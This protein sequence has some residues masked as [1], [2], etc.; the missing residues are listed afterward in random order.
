MRWVFRIVGSVV[1]LILAGFAAVSLVPAEKIADLAAREI[2]AQTG[3]EVRFT[4][5]VKPVFFPVLGIR[6][7]GFTIANANWADDIPMIKADSL[8]VGVELGPLISGVINVRELRIT[9]PAIRLETAR[10]GAVNWEFAATGSTGDAATGDP[11]SLPEFSLKD[12]RI[13]GGS[14]VYIDH[15]AGTQTKIEDVDAAGAFA[16]SGGNAVLKGG[17]R[18]NGE[19]ID[20]NIDIANA[21]EFLAGNLADLS[22]SLSG[23]FGKLNA[24]GMAG[25]NPPAAKLKLTSEISKIGAVLALA[26]QDAGLAAGLPKSAGL[27]GRLTY[28]ADGKLF[29]REAVF[30]LGDTKIAGDLDLSL[31]DRPFLTANLAADALDLSWLTGG[32][33]AEGSEPQTKS[34]GWS[35]SVID[36]SGL[37]AL[38]AEVAFLAGSVDLGTVKVG[39]TRI[40]AKL[41]T[42]RLVV[43]LREVQAYGGNLTGEYVLNARSG[44]SMGGDINGA[45]LQLKPLLTDLADY[46]RLIAETGLKFKFLTSG[47]SM[48]AMM[49]RLSGSGNFNVGAGEVI[50]FDL[51]GMLRNLDASYRGK[52]NKTIFSSITGSFEISDGILQNDDLSFISPLVEATGEGQIDVGAQTIKYRIVPVA[53]SGKDTK[54]SGGISVPVLVKGPWSNLSFRPDL[55]NLLDGE[56]D[57]QREKIEEKLR[58]DVEDAAKK[59]E[60]NLRKDLDKALGEGLKKLLKK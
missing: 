16:G 31:G 58:E 45:G 20:F 37:Q 22:A 27:T 41:D 54:D 33:G 50:G 34:D 10:N 42:G 28:T 43:T 7:G 26:G 13:T 9:N 32:S 48:D 17:A 25:Y 40:R 51:A 1:V 18:L 14:V 29:L 56:L 49:R 46:D 6:T 53:F 52:D 35:K 57:A 55:K 38:D 24:V 8:L 23:D 5:G 2:S 11:S 21:A 19:P 15:A 36:A 3:R 12:G 60:D 44:L 47:Q 59:A 4:G 30:Q 39:K